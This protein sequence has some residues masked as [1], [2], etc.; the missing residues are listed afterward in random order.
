MKNVC[1][2]CEKSS[3][4][5]VV[6][7]K[8]VFNIKGENI[9]VDVEL[10][11]CKNC[12]AVFSSKELG[13]PFKKA[14]RAYRDIKKMVQPDEIVKFRQKY[15]L[16]QKELSSLLGFGEVTLSRYENGS[17]QD[18]THDTLLK[19]VM[20]P[21]NLLELIN[22]KEDLFLDKKKKDLQSRLLKE[23]TVAKICFDLLSSDQ[24]NRLNGYKILDLSKVA[25]A[26]KVF[27]YN[28]DVY[29]TKL[30]K[31]LFYS[32]FLNY[33]VYDFSITG[34]KYAHLPLGPVPDE[35]NFI[36]GALL[37]F[38]KEIEMELV[39]FPQYSG[40]IIKVKS[41]P[42]RSVFSD[43][44]FAILNFVNEKFKELSTNQLIDL[45]HNEQAYI[46][47]KNSDIIPYDFAKEL[48]LDINVT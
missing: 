36:I 37:N 19:L 42:D 27:C 9:N 33:K 20:D 47:T 18:K 48:N 28:R 26:I 16:T 12:D 4:I 2:V 38:D 25:E 46:C 13:D 22:S 45:T 7:N 24:P 23:L 8:Q 39:E 3:G 35:Y 30:F 29:K 21:T 34:L 40:E 41:P 15:D 5:E 1:P 44:E 17:L 6:T 43:T 32:D 31:L 10:F 14:Y 11:H